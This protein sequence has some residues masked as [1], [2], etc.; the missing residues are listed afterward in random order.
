MRGIALN[1][2]IAFLIFAISPVRL[3]GCIHGHC[4]SLLILR[5]KVLDEVTMQ[6]ITNAVVGGRTLTGVSQTAAYEPLEAVVDTDGNFGLEFVHGSL[7]VCPP[8]EFPRPDQVQITIVR[9]GCQQTITIEINQDTARFIE[10]GLED[11]LE[12]TQPILLPPCEES[13]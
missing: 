11:V 9:N 8:P 6:P 2:R 4:V 1:I 10:G 5:G 13:P 7:G 3:S 12:L